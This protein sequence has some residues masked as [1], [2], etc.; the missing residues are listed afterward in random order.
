MLRFA[1]QGHLIGTNV[2]SVSCQYSMF[3]SMLF[4]DHRGGNRCRCNTW[5]AHVTCV[6]PTGNRSTVVLLSF[7]VLS[8]AEDEHMLLTADKDTPLSGVIT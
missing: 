4:S 8:L 5:P 6:N 3:I 2:L 7:I 1:H